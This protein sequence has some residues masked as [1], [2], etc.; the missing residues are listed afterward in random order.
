MVILSLRERIHAPLCSSCWTVLFFLLTSWKRWDAKF[1]GASPSSP[2]LCQK[3]VFCPSPTMTMIDAWK[4]SLS[5]LLQG[6]SDPT[7][8][9]DLCTHSCQ[10]HLRR[11]ALPNFSRS[12]NPRPPIYFG[13]VVVGQLTRQWPPFVFSSPF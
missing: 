3:R 4:S 12:G 8:G 10:S 2:L 7:H 13:L 5:A 6:R 11:R 1:L 9:L